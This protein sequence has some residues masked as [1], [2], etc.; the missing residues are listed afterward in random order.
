MNVVVRACD[1]MRGSHSGGALRRDECPWWVWPGVREIRARH[2]CCLRCRALCLRL[3]R[4]AVL[5]WRCPSCVMFE[6]SGPLRCL[7]AQRHLACAS[8]L[9]GS[10]WLPTPFGPSALSSRV[11]SSR[12]APQDLATACLVLS[13]LPALMAS[14]CALRSTLPR[15]VPFPL[16]PFLLRQGF[17]PCAAW[18]AHCAG[19]VVRP[20]VVSVHPALRC[21]FAMMPGERHASR[22]RARL[23]AALPPCLPRRVQSTLPARSP[24][25][26]GR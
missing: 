18:C 3:R 19:V 6:V 22:N 26:P 14:A 15:A 25:W 12:P 11:E 9:H 24:C 10:A 17:L 13:V 5:S 8:L 20:L 4:W 7:C 16:P 21:F 2:S 1:G 23:P